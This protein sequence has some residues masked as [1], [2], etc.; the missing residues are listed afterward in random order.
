MK[1][2]AQRVQALL[3]AV[4]AVAALAGAGA[5]TSAGS[6]GTASIVGGHVTALQVSTI[7]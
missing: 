3:V 7:H 2:R 1:R 5:G 6:T 4:A